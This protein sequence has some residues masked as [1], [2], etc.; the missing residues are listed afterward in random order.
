MILK[1]SKKT[2]KYCKLKKE[3]ISLVGNTSLT[4]G[5]ASYDRGM[6]ITTS[7]WWGGGGGGR[8]NDKKLEKTQL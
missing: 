7:Y 1:Q 2:A 6:L 4:V 8:V 3:L 5:C